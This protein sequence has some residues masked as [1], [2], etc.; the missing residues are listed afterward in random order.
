[1]NLNLSAKIA[2]LADSGRLQA[3]CWRVRPNVER[4]KGNFDVAVEHR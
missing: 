3:R 4:I 2:D 1:V